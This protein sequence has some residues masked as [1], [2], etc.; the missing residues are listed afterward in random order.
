[1]DFGVVIRDIGCSENHE[2]NQKSFLCPLLA[3]IGLVQP[4]SL[5]NCLADQ[6]VILLQRTQRG[7]EERV[8]EC[9]VRLIDACSET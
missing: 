4:A 2:M 7:G 9:A 1:M 6:G 8:C 5:L 3:Y